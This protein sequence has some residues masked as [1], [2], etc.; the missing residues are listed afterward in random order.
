M[1]T[2]R[3]AVASSLGALGLARDSLVVEHER[4][5]VAVAGVEDARDP[6]PVLGA[7]LGDPAQHLGQLR[8]RNDAV[9]DVVARRDPP[10]RR[11]RRLAAAPDAVRAPRRV[12]AA[13]S[14]NAPQS[15]Q[16]RSTAAESSSDLRR[17]PVELDDQ[18]RARAGRVARARRPPRPPRSSS[19]S[20]ISIAAGRIPAAITCETASPAA[21]VVANA[22]SSVRTVSGDAQDA[23]GDPHGDP[24]RA[25]G[26]DERAEQVGARVVAR[27]RHE[28]AVRQ[29]DVGRED[30]VDGEAVLQAVRAAGVLGDVAADRADLLARR[31]GRVEEAVRRRPRA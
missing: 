2:S 4:M 13:C 26:A 30:V 3:I 15:R 18:H 12:S 21:S 20:I 28:L 22:A 25:L 16:I 29:H 27:E 11:E 17:G 19:A 1:Q 24:E 9:L 6:E 8:A 7:E 10:H 14:S 31:V 5:Q 23:H